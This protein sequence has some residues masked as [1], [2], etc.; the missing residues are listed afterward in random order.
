MDLNIFEKIKKDCNLDFQKRIIT[1]IEYALQLNKIYDNKFED[2]INKSLDVIINQYLKNNFINKQS[3]K[4]AEEILLPLKPYAKKQTVLCVGHA[5]IDINWCWG[6][7][8]TVSIIISTIE[9]MLKLLKK[10]KQFTFAQS[11][12][13]VYRVLEKYRPDL[14]KEVKKYFKEGRFEITAST[15]V[16]ADKNLSNGESQIQQIIQAKNYLSS[17]FDV[18]KDYFCIDFE[19]DTFGHTKQI[20]QIL[21]KS[22]IKYYYHCRGNNLMP[23]YRWHS[24]NDDSI[25]VYR[26]PFWYLGPI[27]YDSF[28]FVCD[29]SKR[30]KTDY[31]LKVYGVG[32]HGGGCSIKDIER[33]IE[34]SKYP[35][36]ANIKFSTFHEFFSLIEKHCKDIPN[37]YGNQSKIFTGCYTSTSQ[38]KDGNF[39]AQEG[40][41]N[42]N[43]ISFLTNS[44]LK[45]ETYNSYLNKMLVNQFHDILPGSGVEKTLY[46]ALG[47]YQKVHA[48]F[49]S[50]ISKNIDDFKKEIDTSLLLNKDIEKDNISIG[51]G[52][53]FLNNNYNYSTSFNYGSTRLFSIFNQLQI[54]INKNIK[55]QLWDYFDD[56]NN[57]EIIDS[58]TLKNIDFVLLDNKSTFYWQ[59]YYY[60]LIINT[61]IHSFSYKTIIV[62]QKNRVVKQID[63]PP[64]FQRTEDEISNLILEND[65]IKYEFDKNDLSLISIFD[66]TSNKEYLSDNAKFELVYE[67]DYYQM[68]SWYFGR[69]KKII[70]LHTNN[71]LIKDSI[72]NNN[73]F[74]SFSFNLKEE[75]IT[76]D[77][78]VSLEKHSKILKF[79]CKTSF[80]NKSL[81]NNGVP[82]IRFKLPLLNNA[83]SA[84]GDIAMGSSTFENKDQD[85]PCQSFLSV[86]DISLIGKARHGF[87]YIDNT[88]YITLLRGSYDPNPYPEIGNRQFE[89][90]I[91]VNTKDISNKILESKMLYLEPFVVTLDYQK[92]K[93]P[94]N[95]QFLK[96]IDDVVISNIYLNKNNQIILRLYNP[97]LNDVLFDYKKYFNNKNCYICDIFE[98]KLNKIQDNL[99]IKPN[100]FITLLFE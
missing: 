98:N 81:L 35:I 51:A 75:N 52:N 27:E 68:T 23:I 86:N 18:D 85:V 54:D 3:A 6:Y 83:T 19:P 84:I 55:I 87:R 66:K 41:Y 74:S 69:I 1:Q 4:K 71:I 47:E 93:Y 99:I 70:S 67:D 88:L 80:F 33:I 61:K 13:F 100:E 64:L 29:F 21:A 38:I 79:S 62:R 36:M 44:P 7:E 72:I 76:L 95:N 96:Q 57:I 65:L 37:I 59:H 58:E 42:L 92:G 43:A 78:N 8:E 26:E 5:H 53:G 89:F 56:I 9:T 34:I 17:L 24:D 77:V 97:N 40:F 46:F 12:A 49:S 48:G 2:L 20:P 90:A 16:E 30:Y 11:Q 14:L 31:M 94:L 63:Y 22:G 10:Y 45:R 91:S 39:N 73:L 32:D 25:L 60:E 82:A 28:N 50:I 15:Y